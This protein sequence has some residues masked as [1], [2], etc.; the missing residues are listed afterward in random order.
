MANKK[1][2]RGMVRSDFELR[3]AKDLEK[4]KVKFEYESSKLTYKVPERSALYCPDFI[5]DNGIIIEAKGRLTTADRKKMVLVKLSNPTLDIRFI[6]MRANNPIRKGSK[7]TYAIWAEKHAF[8]W[9]EGTVPSEWLTN[10][11]EVK[12]Q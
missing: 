5:L 6:F 8:P 2:S 11:N 10:S 3:I 7:T 1:M 12:N 4:R 9:C